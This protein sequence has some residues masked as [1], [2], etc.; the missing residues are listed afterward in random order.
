MAEYRAAPSCPIHVQVKPSIPH[1]LEL[2]PL[3]PPGLQDPESAAG[4]VRACTVWVP[5]SL[6]TGRVQRAGDVVAARTWVGGQPAPS[7]PGRASMVRGPTSHD[8]AVT[9]AVQLVHSP[10]PP[11]TVGRALA[12]RVICTMQPG[13][14]AAAPHHRLT[15]ADWIYVKRG[16]VR[17][18][19][20]MLL[21]AGL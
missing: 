3:D 20:D 6:A 7:M 5:S 13:S 15:I 18:A 8:R 17:S 16:A 12:H 2:N 9:D 4:S 10:G 11:Y 21:G 19:R 14:T 1:G